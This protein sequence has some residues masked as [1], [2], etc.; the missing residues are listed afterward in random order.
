MARKD[1][2][3]VILTERQDADARI[4][5]DGAGLGLAISYGQHWGEVY[6][7]HLS[8][9]D[10]INLHF[11][12][13]WYFWCRW[14]HC[15]ISDADESIVVFLMLMKPPWYFWCWWTH[16]GISDADEPTVVFL[17]LM[18]PLWYF[19]C[20]WT[21]HGISDVDK[22]IIV[23]LKLLLNIGAWGWGVAV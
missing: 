15:G 9:G 16:C 10:H 1:L 14:I 7:Q 17:M 2:F 5:E 21:Q 20:W 11:F 22:P 23:T 13:S 6:G 18:N 8:A 12:K 19:W 3:L 4:T